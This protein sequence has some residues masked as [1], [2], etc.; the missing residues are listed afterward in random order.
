ME[1]SNKNYGFDKIKLNHRVYL[2]DV[3]FSK[4][5]DEEYFKNVFKNG[6]ISKSAYNKFLANKRLTYMGEHENIEIALYFAPIYGNSFAVDIEEIEEFENYDELNE[7]LSQKDKKVYP[8]LY[9]T[10]QFSSKIIDPKILLYDFEEV[11]IKL[12]DYKNAII[13]NNK[14]YY[15]ILSFNISRI[16]SAVDVKIDFDFSTLEA[17]SDNF[18]VPYMKVCRKYINKDNGNLETILRGS[19]KSSLVIYNKT[20]ELKEV[21]N[22]DINK[23]IV[24]LEWQIKKMSEFEE[25]ENIRTFGAFLNHKDYILNV[26]KSYLK[27]LYTLNEFNIARTYEGQDNCLRFIETNKR[28]AIKRFRKDSKDNFGILRKNVENEFGEREN[29]IWKEQN[30]NSFEFRKL[31]TNYNLPTHKEPKN[32]GYKQYFE[33]DERLKYK[34][35]KLFL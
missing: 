5:G 14:E 10:F 18:Y 6:Y 19:K 9:L 22:I 31:K 26:F 13:K 11:I 3:D 35:K 34:L 23:N 25:F 29:K 27:D 24:R 16:D 17:F 8:N 2:E 1:A 4:F 7:G 28:K 21:Q 20:V 32:R 12:N 30:I 33:K 15:D